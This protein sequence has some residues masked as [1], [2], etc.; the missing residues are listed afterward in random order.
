MDISRNEQK[1]Y[2][3]SILKLFPSQ[4]DKK[5]ISLYKDINC[6]LDNFDFYEIFYQIEERSND[7]EKKLSVCMTKCMSMIQK[8][9]KKNKNKL[10]GQ[11]KKLL[12]K[13]ILSNYTQYYYRKN[14]FDLQNSVNKLRSNIHEILQDIEYE[15]ENVLD[16]LIDLLKDCMKVTLDI[17]NEISAWKKLLQQCFK[18]FQKKKVPKVNF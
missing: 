4:N 17:H 1:V 13:N 18:M 6:E 12:L 8:Y 9:N 15:I 14:F 10:N 11:Q 3:T 7:F 16:Q 2:T 5:L